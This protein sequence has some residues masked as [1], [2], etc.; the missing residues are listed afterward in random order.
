MDHIETGGSLFGFVRLEMTDEMPADRQI[1]STLHL[2]KSFLQLV[3]SEVH[4]T[5]LGGSADGVGSE[6]LGNGD[7]PNRGG[8]APGPTGGARDSVANRSQPGP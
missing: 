7:E 4:L 6:R 5:R 8:I 3:L 1:R 2:E